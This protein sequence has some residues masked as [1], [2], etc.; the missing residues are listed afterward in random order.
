MV[1]TTSLRDRDLALLPK[2][3]IGPSAVHVVLFHNG[4][5]ILVWNKEDKLPNGLPKPAGWGNPGGRVRDGEI[6]L[7]AAMR[8]AIEETGGTI[9]KKFIKIFPVPLFVRRNKDR[10]DFFFLGQ[11][12]I[13]KELPVEEK[14]KIRDP[15][16][17]VPYFTVISPQKIQKGADNKF[18]IFENE[19]VYSRHKSAIDTALTVIPSMLE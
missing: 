7:H 6:P 15:I 16:D 17:K 9:D 10:I 18:S 3:E 19:V 4:D 5:I 13:D 8:E 12:S 2:E 14:I 11:V 1:H